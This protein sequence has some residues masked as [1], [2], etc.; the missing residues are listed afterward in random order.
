MQHAYVTQNT[1]QQT[2]VLIYNVPLTASA[3]PI[4]TLTVSKVGTSSSADCAGAG[5]LFVMDGSGSTYAYTLPIT[6]SPQPSF[7]LANNGVACALDAS[8]NLYVTAVE[9]NGMF[10]TD[11]FEV[12]AAPVNA[13]SSATEIIQDPATA[14]PWMGVTTDPT[15]DAF[16]DG[17]N[18]RITEFS[19]RA[20]GNK[21]LASFGP[22]QGSFGMAAGPDGNLYVAFSLSGESEIDVYNPNSG[23][24]TK[25]I[26][27]E[28]GLFPLYIAFDASSNMVV[29][30]QATASQSTLLVLAP[31]YTAVTATIP[32]PSG[33]S[34]IAIGQ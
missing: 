33:I 16:M 31:P 30:A 12:Y 20:S 5:A 6:S 4:A 22:A 11:T 10:S 1:P 24:K 18:S 26:A 15:G 28:K 17:P 9:G 3:Q 19:S 21:Q 23:L 34:G 8:G 14:L 29:T 27:I 7:T 2:N 32:A 25:T 13:S